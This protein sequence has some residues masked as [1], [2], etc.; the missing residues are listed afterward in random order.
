MRF[1][2][3]HIRT[4]L[5]D[6]HQWDGDD[7]V[8]PGGLALTSRIR[9]SLAD[10]VEWTGEPSI[11]DNVGWQFGGNWAGRPFW[12]ELLL[13]DD[14]T[15]RLC[16]LVNRVLWTR[17]SREMA[18][19]TALCRVIDERLRTDNQI[20]LLRWTLFED[21]WWFMKPF[22]GSWDPSPSAVR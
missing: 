21:R 3:A 20:Q 19:L 10:S 15:F 17:R 14:E 2:T 22:D 4:Q 6:D 13:G 7:L 1:A 16:V 18:L 12:F 11:S 8:L 5:P 9:Q